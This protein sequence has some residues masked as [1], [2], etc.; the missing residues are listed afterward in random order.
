MLSVSIKHTDHTDRTSCNALYR[1]V[2]MSCLLRVCSEYRLLA[3]LMVSEFCSLMFVS[4]LGFP[5]HH[6]PYV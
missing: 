3:M 2:I 5:N 4:C 6:S 1:D